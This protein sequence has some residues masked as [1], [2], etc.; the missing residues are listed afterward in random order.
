MSKRVVWL[1]KD[2][3]DALV[4]WLSVRGVGGV[5]RTT[6]V[7]IALEAGWAEIVDATP[8][9]EAQS[10]PPYRVRL[11]VSIEDL[12]VSM[13]ALLQLNATAQAISGAEEHETLEH[14]A[15]SVA[16]VEKARVHHRSGLARL[17]VGGADGTASL[18]MLQAV[19]AAVRDTR[20][21]G[22]RVRVVVVAIRH[23]MNAP[24]RSC[25][26]G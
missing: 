2:L 7:R 9:E 8:Q 13:S 14:L 23:E 4:R 16:G 26:V 15:L 24:R 22:S 5:S 25:V 18:A 17:S 3:G 19:A 10:V 11:L 12:I 20:A 21:H 6:S 1:T